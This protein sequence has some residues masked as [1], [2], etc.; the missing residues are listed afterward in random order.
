MTTPLEIVETP[1]RPNGSGLAALLAAGA[2]CLAMAILAIAGDRSA[3]VKNVLVF[4]KPTGVLSGVTTV[5]ILLWLA[6]WAILEWRWSSREVDAGRISAISLL[7]LV[8]SL[9]L[10]FPPVADLF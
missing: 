2:G 8:L 7:L 5:A 6:I 1:A 3:F 9:I 10:T 4:Y